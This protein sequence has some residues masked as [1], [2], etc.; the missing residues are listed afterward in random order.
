MSGRRHSQERYASLEYSYYYFLTKRSL[1][2]K[3]CFIPLLALLG[4]QSIGPQCMQAVFHQRQAL[5]SDFNISPNIVV[6]CKPDIEQNC[7]NVHPKG[8]I[9]CLMG[10]AKEQVPMGQGDNVMMQSKISAPCSRE[11]NNLLL[12]ADVAG[13][14]RVD[15]L[16][17]EACQNIID[18]RCSQVKSSAQ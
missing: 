4:Q 12:G 14:V 6:F 9:H 13:D 16:L 11:L 15:T 17:Y 2:S 18:H 7:K 1:I 10:V 8:I 3:Y 5:M